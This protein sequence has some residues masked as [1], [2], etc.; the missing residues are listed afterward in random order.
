MRIFVALGADQYLLSRIAEFLP[1]GW[2]VEELGGWHDLVRRLS[3]ENPPDVLLFT[4]KHL[5]DDVRRS[6]IDLR[7]RRQFVPAAVYLLDPNPAAAHFAGRLHR[8][9]IEPI[10]GPA[11]L[12]KGITQVIERAAPL[13]GAAI[14]RMLPIPGGIGERLLA[15]LESDAEMIAAAPQRLALA[16]GT[17]RSALYRGLQNEGLPPPGEI[18]ALFRLWPGVLRI[19]SGG[20]GVDAAVEADCPHY[21]SFRKAVA[22]H[23]GMTIREVRRAEGPAALLR[24]WTAFQ[25]QAQAQAES[26]A[27]PGGFTGSSGSR[28]SGQSGD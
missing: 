14:A 12:R 8:H 28:W 13:V 16:L 9:G 25:R 17:S 2:A 3:S 7:K 4:S 23:F 20:R 18:Q 1:A 6:I 24:R 27:A 11:D 10:F 21:P 19:W 15:L 5:N 26:R 22:T